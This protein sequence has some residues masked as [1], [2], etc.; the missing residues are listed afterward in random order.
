[1][2][3]KKFGYCRMTTVVD[4]MMDGNNG[5]GNITLY[6]VGGGARPLGY[7]GPLSGT[8]TT[9]AD[10]NNN[11]TASLIPNLHLPPSMY[12]GSAPTSTTMV[13]ADSMPVKAPLMPMN[14]ERDSGLTYSAVPRKRPRYDDNPTAAAADQQLLSSTF[15]FPPPS[16]HHHRDTSGGSFTFLGQDMSFEIQQQ[17]FEIDRFIAHQTVKVKMEMEERRK[18]Y[19]R[20]ILT[21]VEETVRKKLRAKEEEIERIGRLNW[22]LE[23]KVKSLCVENQIW[24]ELAQSNEATANALRTNLEQVLLAAAASQA[25]PPQQQEEQDV[26]RIDNNDLCDDAQSC[27]GSNQNNIDDN[28]NPESYPIEDGNDVNGPAGNSAIPLSN[29]I[30]TVRMKTGGGGRRCRNCGKEEASVLVLPCRHLCLCGGCGPSLQTCP[31]CLCTKNGTLHINLS[32]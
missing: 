7:G 30:E 5:G 12:G 23:E 9:T 11:N 25:Q 4:G 15:Q 1:M 26:H 6:G 17:Q 14:S 18:S 8:T 3:M 28:P 29:E 20:R 2:M 31:I 19:S 32:S 27:C 21:A 10:N 24:R 22:A 16:H 13:A